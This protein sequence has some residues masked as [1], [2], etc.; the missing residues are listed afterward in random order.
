MFYNSLG[1]LAGWL[2]GF[3]HYEAKQI[4]KLKVL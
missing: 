2:A 4:K 1:W 3:E